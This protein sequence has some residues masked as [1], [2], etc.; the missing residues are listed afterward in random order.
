METSPIDRKIDLMLWDFPIESRKAVSK[1]IKDNPVETILN[2][3]QLMLRILNTMNWYDL[4]KIF[5]IKNLTLLLSDSNIQKLF[6][7]QRQTY[8]Q[9]ARRLLSKY[10]LSPTE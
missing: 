10:S 1:K 7:K 3:Q 6:P 9:N 4:I 2:D 8:Y 5:G